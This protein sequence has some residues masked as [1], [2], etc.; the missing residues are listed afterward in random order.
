MRLSAVSIVPYCY[1]NCDPS[2][3]IF[4]V[5]MSEEVCILAKSFWVRAVGGFSGVGTGDNSIPGI[6]LL[7][8]FAIL[9]VD[10]AH[11]VLDPGR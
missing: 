3:I 7:Q 10:F 6:V 9:G 2:E 1:A 8:G 4:S 5:P 11:F